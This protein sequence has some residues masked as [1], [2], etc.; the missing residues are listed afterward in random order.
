LKPRQAKLL[1]K[2]EAEW[3]KDTNLK[4]EEALSQ[5][6]IDDN[7]FNSFTSVF[8]TIEKM[9][10]MRDLGKGYPQ[11]KPILQMLTTST[12][13]AVMPQFIEDYGRDKK[14]DMVFSP[15]HDLFIDGVPNAKPTGIYMDK[16]G[17]FKAQINIPAQINIETMP[18]MWEPIRHIY[19]TLVAKC[20]I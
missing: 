14:I 3:Y 11:A 13:G 18:G 5:I 7:M 2:I 10:S 9:F 12:I 1:K 17:N 16:N 6:Y 15:S 8:T 20:R 4:G 19:V